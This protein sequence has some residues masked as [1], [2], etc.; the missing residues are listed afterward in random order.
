[1]IGRAIDLGGLGTSE[2]LMMGWAIDKVSGKVLFQYLD[3]ET[4]RCA[5]YISR[6]KENLYVCADEKNIPEY[7][8]ER[9]LISLLLFTAEKKYNP[10]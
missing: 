1:M 3:P 8:E 6:Q 7:T 4:S 9:T 10:L 5:H 2:V